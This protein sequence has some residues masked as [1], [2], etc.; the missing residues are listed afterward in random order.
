MCISFSIYL[1]YPCVAKGLMQ[2]IKRLSHPL[3]GNVV[4]KCIQVTICCQGSY[5]KH[6]ETKY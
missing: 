6:L 2:S 1:S 3:E 4:S 5:M